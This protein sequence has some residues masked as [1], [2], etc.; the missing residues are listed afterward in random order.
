MPIKK[1]LIEILWLDAEDLEP[2]W[3]YFTPTDI[4]HTHLTATYGLFVGEDDHFIYHASTFN[5]FTDEWAGQGK[6]PKGMVHSIQ[7]I[8][9]VYYDT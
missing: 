6:I 4:N 9:V 2:G 3:T 1:E 7:T 8:Q 5:P